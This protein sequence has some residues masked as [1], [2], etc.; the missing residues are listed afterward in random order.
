MR[1]SFTLLRSDYLYNFIVIDEFN[2]PEETVDAWIEDILKTEAESKGWVDY[3]W[4]KHKIVSEYM[5]PKIT[6]Y[7]VEA[8]GRAITEDDKTDE[9][10]CISSTIDKLLCL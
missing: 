10:L 9:C 2:T 4:V 1:R 7:I 5:W 3:Q 8:E 6:Y